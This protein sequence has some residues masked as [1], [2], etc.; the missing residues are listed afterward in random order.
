MPGQGENDMTHI[1]NFQN[2]IE[3]MERH[4]QTSCQCQG[5][6]GDGG[7]LSP[8]NTPELCELGRQI[9]AALSGVTHKPRPVEFPLDLLGVGETNRLE[10]KLR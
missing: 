6:D 4:N 8:E 5:D 2:A 7:K 9:E 3:L 10:R 1:R